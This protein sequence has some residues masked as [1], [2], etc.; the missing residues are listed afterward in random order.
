M[1]NAE[2]FKPT[3][4]S[5]NNSFVEPALL[6]RHDELAWLFHQARLKST[7][8]TRQ[9]RGFSGICVYQEKEATRGKGAEV[10]VHM[11]GG[12]ASSDAAL[13]VPG[14]PLVCFTMPLAALL[15]NGSG[16][17]SSFTEPSWNQ[18]L[19]QC[20]WW[21]VGTGMKWPLCFP[22]TTWGYCLTTCENQVEKEH[23]WGQ[24]SSAVEELRAASSHC[25]VEECLVSPD[26][27]TLAEILLLWATPLSPRLPGKQS[28]AGS[29]LSEI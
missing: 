3:Q 17:V 16:A 29:V 11:A 18:E 13:A 10:L 28:L 4:P 26:A 24:C 8:C 6:S 1:G 20:L 23:L 27:G 25:L 2:K 22:G 12:I 9:S 5:A 14:G 15:G 19:S 7:G 21:E